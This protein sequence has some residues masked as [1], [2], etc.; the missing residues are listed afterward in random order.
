MG[1]IS[2]IPKWKFAWDMEKMVVTSNDDDESE[3]EY[4]YVSCPV[5]LRGGDSGQKGFLHT[6]REIPH[7]ENDLVEHMVNSER[8]AGFLILSV[9]RGIQTSAAYLAAKNLLYTSRLYLRRA[10]YTF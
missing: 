6:R 10:Q 8:D 3:A 1:G 4:T 7:G 9:V 5:G 2:I